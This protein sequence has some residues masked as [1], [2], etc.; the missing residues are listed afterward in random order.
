MRIEIG[1]VTTI[2]DGVALVAIEKNMA[3]AK[4]HAGCACALGTGTMVVEA[5]DPLGVHAEQIVEMTVAQGSALH[6]AVVV[7]L[8]PLL[9]LIG[10]MLLG[11]QIGK[12]SGVPNAFEAMCGFGGLALA[13]FAV[14]WYDRRIARS[15]RHQPVITKVVG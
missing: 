12:R 4:C 5:R 8:L 10:G 1:R 3:C 11:E 15:M 9:A 7:Y 13:F 14:H 6:A 2:R